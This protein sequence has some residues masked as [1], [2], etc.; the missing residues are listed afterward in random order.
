M[1]KKDIVIG[2]PALNEEATILHVLSMVSMGLQEF[3]PD[4]KSLIVVADGCSKDRT[5]HLAKSFRVDS[6]IEKKVVKAPCNKGKGSTIKKIMQVA[7]KVDANMLAIMDSDLISIKP[8]WVDYLLRPIAFGIADFTVSRYIRDRHDGG[9]TKLLTYPMITSLWGEEVRQPMG[10]E[11]GMSSE[12]IRCCLDHPLFPD[13]FGID[14]FLTTVVLV[15]N[16]RIHGGILDPKFH[17]STSKYVDPKS[18]LLPMFNQV[19]TTL[20]DMMVYYEKEW[21]SRPPLPLVHAGR[22]RKLDRYKGPQP[23]PA[24]IDT[25]AFGDTAQRI[26]EDNQDLLKEIDKDLANEVLDRITNKK[27]FGGGIWAETVIRA[28]TKYKKTKDRGIIELLG[29]IWVV[30]Y[31]SFVI[32]TQNMDLNVAELD[33]H[34]QMLLFLDKR[35]L[36][37]EI[38]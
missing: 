24:F 27:H 20:F 6:N 11:V 21:K 7:E 2:I 36:L 14:T 22:P 13:H 31:A 17:E 15:N 5:V 37:M 30:R 38:F 34:K 26:I 33:V 28:A 32:L 4:Y 9:I 3:Y 8:S 16:F 29:G 10:G 25:A 12:V 18:H 35:D 19:T 1:G 23:T